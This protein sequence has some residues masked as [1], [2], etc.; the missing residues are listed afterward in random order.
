M[1]SKKRRTPCLCRIQKCKSGLFLLQKV[2]FPFLVTWNSRKIALFLNKT[3]FWHLT[4]WHLQKFCIFEVTF[5]K[6][7][8]SLCR[9]KMDGISGMSFKRE[10]ALSKNVEPGVKSAFLD[11][12]STTLSKKDAYGAPTKQKRTLSKNAEPG[13]NSTFLDK[14]FRSVQKKVS[15]KHH[16]NEKKPTQKM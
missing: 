12:F 6:K 16:P 8:P 13:V 1:P 10:K 14:L 3:F 15:W 5:C 11:N 7:K 2:F 9:M 4:S